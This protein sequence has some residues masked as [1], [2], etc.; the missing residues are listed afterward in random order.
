MCRLQDDEEDWKEEST[1]MAD[2]Y[3]NTYISEAATCAAD[4]CTD[5]F[6]TVR[7]MHSPNVIQC[8]GKGGSIET[9]LYAHTCHSYHAYDPADKSH[10][11]VYR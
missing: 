6:P 10:N 3:Q 7:T 5:M 1:K 4:R 8:P 11:S 9:Q 2:S